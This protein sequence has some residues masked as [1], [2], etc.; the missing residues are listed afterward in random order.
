MLDRVRFIFWVLAVFCVMGC[1][2]QN[3]DAIILTKEHIAAAIPNES[4]ARLDQSRT[5]S[6]DEITVDGYVMKPKMRG[7]GRDP[8]ALKDEQWLA[9]VRIIN[10]GRTFNVPVPQAQF[11][12]LREGNRVHVRYR[13]G[14]YTGT[15]WGAEITP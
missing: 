10:G 2:K 12:K 9:K 15:V 4:A 14:K 6:D 5:I 7:T 8:R 3:G 13:V 1:E 11:E